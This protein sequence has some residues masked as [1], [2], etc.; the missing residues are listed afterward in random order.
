MLILVILAIL[1][2]TGYYVWHAKS[3]TDN[4]YDNAANAQKT[5][6][7]PSKIKSFADCQKATG[8]LIQESYPEVCV[9]K[10]GQRFV[11]PINAN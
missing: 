8:S 7:Q 1:G 2:F 3:S 5:V 4:T 9:T 6:V 10:S 11:Q